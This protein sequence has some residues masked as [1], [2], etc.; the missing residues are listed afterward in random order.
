MKNKSLLKL[1]YPFEYYKSI[2]KGLHVAI[3]FCV[4]FLPGIGCHFWGVGPQDSPTMD[5]EPV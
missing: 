5:P 2:K 4:L 1:N 3:K